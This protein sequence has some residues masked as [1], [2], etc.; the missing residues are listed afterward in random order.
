LQWRRIDVPLSEQD[1]AQW[2]V[3]LIEE[4]EAA[5]DGRAGLA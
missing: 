4:A 5:L 2:D 3:A 1:P